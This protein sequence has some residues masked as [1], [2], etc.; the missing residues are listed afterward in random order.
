MASTTMGIIFTLPMK[1]I[2]IVVIRAV[3]SLWLIFLLCE[4]YST[5]LLSYV[6][7]VYFV[8]VSIEFLFTLDVWSAMRGNMYEASGEWK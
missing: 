1:P 8:F 7:L 2:E 5:V 6:L 3:L 4:S